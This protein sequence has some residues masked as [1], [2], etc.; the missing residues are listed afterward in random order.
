MD[1][2]AKGFWEIVQFILKWDLK[3]IE[4]YT[5]LSETLEQL[6]LAMSTYHES[7]FANCG[8]VMD[9]WNCTVELSHIIATECLCTNI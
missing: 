6:D 2:F 1:K 5:I 4:F 9:M 3:Y 8:P 7:L